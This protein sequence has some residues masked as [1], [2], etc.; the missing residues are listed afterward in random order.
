MVDFKKN[1]VFFRNANETENLKR[2]SAENLFYLFFLACHQCH[3]KPKSKQKKK[4]IKKEK[5]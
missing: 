2:N 5:K 3:V 4:K 1:A